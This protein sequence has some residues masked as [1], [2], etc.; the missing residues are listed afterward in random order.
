MVRAVESYPT[1]RAALILG[2]TVQRFHRLARLHE[3]EPVFQ[4]TGVTGE[5]FWS[6]KDIARLAEI[7]GDAA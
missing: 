1:K 3:V 7:I 2:V 5:K 4:A 6:P